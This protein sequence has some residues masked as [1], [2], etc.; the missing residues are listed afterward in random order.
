LIK[1]EDKKAE[2]T[3]T[4]EQVKGEIAR[5]L[6]AE[7]EL[8]EKFQKLEEA[9]TK[10]D[11]ATVENQLKAWKVTWDETGEFDLQAEAIPKLAGAEALNEA[12]WSLG[13]SGQWL[14]HL[15]RDGSLRYILKMKELKKVEAAPK[16]STDMAQSGGG[17]GLFEAWLENAREKNKVI[18]NLT[19]SQ[20]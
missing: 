17:S 15:V 7:M 3:Q 12:V 19:I 13:Y 9:L 5:K 8:D 11:E 10:K 1:V 2:S 16:P 18:R 20:E 14:D 4:L 6:I